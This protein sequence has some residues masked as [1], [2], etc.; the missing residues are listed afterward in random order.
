MSGKQGRSGGYREGAGRPPQSIRLKIG[1]TLIV[2]DGGL[3]ERGKVVDITRS[4]VKIEVADRV[5]TLT[6]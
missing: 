5:I 1:D 6:R 4:T 2:S 3:Y